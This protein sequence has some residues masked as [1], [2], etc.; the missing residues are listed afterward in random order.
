MLKLPPLTNLK[1]MWKDLKSLSAYDVHVSKH[2]SFFKKRDVMKVDLVSKLNLSSL[3][4]LVQ[5]KVDADSVFNHSGYVDWT[6]KVKE[7]VQKPCIRY[8]KDYCPS[9]LVDAFVTRC[10]GR[11]VR[12]AD[13]QVQDQHNEELKELCLKCGYGPKAEERDKFILYVREKSNTI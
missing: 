3:V 11:N 9:V 7:I 13:Q 2:T 8:P 6:T 1:I 5:P 10:K 12:N 4:A